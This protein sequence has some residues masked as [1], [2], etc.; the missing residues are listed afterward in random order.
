MLVTESSKANAAPD[1]PLLA[2]ERIKKVIQF[3]EDI[4]NQPQLSHP[5]LQPQ[6]LA[7]N[8][9]KNINKETR[10]NSTHL[11]RFVEN[12]KPYKS[13]SPRVNSVI[14]YRPPYAQVQP[15]PQTQIGVALSSKNLTV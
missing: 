13:I 15:N 4:K 11:N 5:P 12:T 14:A 8:F 9:Q 3:K 7:V 2:P 1:A 10:T 6:P